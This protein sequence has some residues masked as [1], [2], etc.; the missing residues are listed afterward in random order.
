[1]GGKDR[2]RYTKI[3]RETRLYT[4]KNIFYMYYTRDSLSPV[5]HFFPPCKANKVFIPLCRRGINILQ[6][7]FPCTTHE[8]HGSIW[9]QRFIN[10][11]ASKGH[12][13]TIPPIWKAALLSHASRFGSISPCGIDSRR[14]C[15]IHGPRGG[16]HFVGWLRIG[17]PLPAG[18]T[19][20]IL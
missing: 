8:N 11:H 17:Q 10:H 2:N 20:V 5:L 13:M 12:I 7:Y 9:F 16:R 15:E 6:G 19:L 4:Y 1:M 14:W 3:E 18:G